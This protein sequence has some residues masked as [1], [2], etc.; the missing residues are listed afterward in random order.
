MELISKIQALNL[1]R[2]KYG[3]ANGV[4]FDQKR[5]ICRN[6]DNRTVYSLTQ[7]LFWSQKKHFYRKNFKTWKFETEFVTLSV[8]SGRDGEN[9]RS[10]TRCDIFE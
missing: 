10:Y 6:R 8:H 5:R 2:L 4:P 9:I 7:T 3:Q 1:Y